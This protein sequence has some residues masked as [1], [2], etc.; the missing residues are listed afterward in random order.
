MYR[1]L[2]VEDQDLMRLALM[3]ELKENV[4]D[5]YI[6]GA[7]TFELAKQLLDEGEFDIVIVDPGLPGFDPTSP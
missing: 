2:I 4:T 6:A 7:Q 5:C 1:A 3:A